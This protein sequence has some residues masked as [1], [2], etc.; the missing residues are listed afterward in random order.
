MSSIVKR[1]SSFL[2]APR[3]RTI[4]LLIGGY[5]VYT[6]YRND[7]ILYK[8]FSA[9]RHR[10]GQT[11]IDLDLDN[12]SIVSNE[13]RSAFATAEEVRLPQ[14]VSA[15]NS[16]KDDPRVTGL[17]VRGISGLQ[18]MGL[19]E[20]SELRDTIRDFSNSWGKKHTMLHIPEGIGG[21]GN[22]TIPLYFASAFDSVHVQPTSGVII[23][24]LSLGTLF[25]KN[26][27][28]KLGVKAKKVARKDFKT[29][30]NNFTEDKFTD[31]HREST[32]SLLDAIMKDIVSAVAKGRNLT[33]EKVMNAIN[34][35]ILTVTEAQDLG[36]VDEALYRDELPKAMRQK[37]LH[38][39]EARKE[40]RE[41]AEL[42]WRQ[43]MTDLKQAWT[44]QGENSWYNIWEDGRFVSNLHDMNYAIP[45]AVLF[46]D[47]QQE[48][49]ELSIK[50]ELRA[51]K[52]HLR[53]LETRPWEAYAANDENEKKSV[54]NSIPYISSLI[55]AE[56]AVC[57]NAIA[58][59]EGMPKFMA[60]SRDPND[61]STF[62]WE[63][64]DLGPLIRWCRSVWRAK[65]MA[66]R[67]VS[68]VMD[69][70][71]HL[72]GLVRGDSTEEDNSIIQSRVYKPRLFLVGY[73]EE[74]ETD[75]AEVEAI[76]LDPES[77]DEDETE[78]N[79]SE[80]E[81]LAP[82]G[83]VET[84]H[85]MQK[86]LIGLQSVKEQEKAVEP[87]E[88]LDLRYQRLNDYIDTL[89]TEKRAYYSKATPMFQF[90]HSG[91]IDSMERNSMFHLQRSGHLFSPW[92]IHAPPKGNYIAV[93]HIDGGISDE[94]ADIVRS[95]IRRADKDPLI[96]AIVLRVNSPGGSATAS[97]LISRA[98]EVAAKPVVASMSSVCASGGYFIS[99]PCD[100]VLASNT[101]I[102]GSIGVIFTAFNSSNLFDTV[103]ITTDRCSR[104]KY[105]DYY[106]ALSTVTEWSEE[107]EARMNKLIDT[108]Y[109]D[110]LDVVSRGRKLDPAETERVAQGRVWAGSEAI[111]LGLVDEIG[112]LQDAVRVAA[113]LA[114]LT[115][116]MDVNAID[117]PT[118]PMLLQDA[119][120]RRGLIPSHIDEEGDESI[121]EK[122]KRSRFWF[123]PGNNQDHNEDNDAVE[124]STT[125]W[126]AEYAD[127]FL[128][129][130]KIA[131]SKI[132][133]QLDLFLISQDRSFLAQT[134]EGILFKG[135]MLLDSGK[136][137]RLKE[138]LEN[139]KNV[140]G[141]PAALAPGIHIDE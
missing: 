44:K 114:Q 109:A 43:A 117:Y 123:L 106:G 83:T 11:V 100:K 18:S 70:E 23:P 61:K 79:D 74:Y 68:T 45:C 66:A 131:L 46:C 29:A 86:A 3:V 34:D 93:V 129:F 98:V 40:A 136:A 99:A 115:P 105:A 47:D 50:E 137:K 89:S 127:M 51:L 27:L 126:S 125:G 97:D 81:S 134:I 31:A 52:A 30:A 58:A 54:Y 92:R 39:V 94:T 35:G 120:R 2:R 8:R 135:I 128:D 103:G 141:K 90:R 13:G 9:A 69:T 133:S 72:S 110:F 124:V 14:L 108:C 16:A 78:E 4:I 80:P 140:S 37:L 33:K 38:N 49:V 87:C 55:E 84:I 71:E 7:N 67:M 28:E 21:F 60:A 102:T 24:G 112:G 77:N 64:E 25:F 1:F 59:L 15:L 107:F 10:P 56:R 76:K 73:A 88:K 65:C 36:L 57:E 91:P 6:Y 53:W 22:G 62:R 95:A 122:R 104:G 139:M 32:E 17:V 12:V 96:K 116:E 119:A 26:M 111:Q 113:D 130:P 75:T 118:T 42:E 5:K 19:A 63:R 41:N 121:T 20:I 85:K 101:T 82:S 138:E 48:V 132:L